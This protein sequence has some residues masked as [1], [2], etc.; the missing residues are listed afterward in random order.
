MFSAYIMSAQPN[1]DIKMKSPEHKLH[2]CIVQNNAG[3]DISS[4]LE[5]I[6]KLCAKQRHP[7]IIAIPEVFAFRGDNAG[8]RA[9]AQKIPGTLTGWISRFA[10]E[11]RAC[12]LAGSILEKKGAKI[13]NT[14]IVTDRNGKI[15]ARY[16]KIHLFE[17]YLPDGKTIKEADV[18]SP[19]DHPS[20]FT[21]EGWRCGLSICYDIRFPELYRHYSQL[22]AH[23]LFAPANF[24]QKTGRDHWELL[25]RTRA[26]ENQ[27]F[28]VAPN[29]CGANPATK[30]KSYGNSMAV[31]PWG[32]VIARAGDKARVLNV[33]LD[34][35][36][37]TTI[38]TRIPALNHRRL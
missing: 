9:S 7:D 11:H 37:L 34:P 24:T 27:C 23:I 35:E 15:I 12:V 5:Q 36:E 38:R 26:V 32:N 13:F 22:G 18:Y 30:I 29:Q 4:N 6:K 20:M 21:F 1:T 14:C 3:I 10:K 8:Y 33:T 19:G 2:V 28:V 31:A 25:L 17:A 16:R